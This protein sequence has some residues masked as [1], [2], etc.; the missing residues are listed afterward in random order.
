MEGGTLP[1]HEDTDLTV[2]VKVSA[3]PEERS[4]GRA[5]GGCWNSAGDLNRTT[6]R[7]PKMFSGV[8]RCS[9]TR[10]NHL[11]PKWM[12]GWRGTAMIGTQQATLPVFRTGRV[13]RTPQCHPIRASNIMDCSCSPI[14]ISI[15]RIIGT[16]VI[17]RFFPEE[18]T[19][20][21]CC[22]PQPL[23]DDSIPAPD[24]STP[25]MSNESCQ[26][27]IRAFYIYQR[28]GSPSTIVASRF[29]ISVPS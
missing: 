17:T 7:P 18:I 24:R 23:G 20:N 15:P 3:L 22:R 10:Q 12:K 21:V 29:P 6:A 16:C 28:L 9:Q 5:C 19:N 2:F 4:S 14:L 27:L 8:W 25:L 26:D 13:T 1:F 11:L